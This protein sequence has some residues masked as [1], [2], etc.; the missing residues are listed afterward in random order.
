MREA[1]DYHLLVHIGIGVGR[2]DRVKIKGQ[3]WH[4]STAEKVLR[5]DELETAGT[6]ECCLGFWWLLG[7]LDKGGDRVFLFM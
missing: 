4:F 7:G 1:F 3:G 2:L 6:K 5:C